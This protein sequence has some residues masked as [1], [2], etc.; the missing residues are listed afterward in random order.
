MED[1]STPLDID[2]LINSNDDIFLPMQQGS[3]ISTIS[4]RQ[5]L[6]FF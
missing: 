6:I 1:V 4:R 3:S 5:L 2:S